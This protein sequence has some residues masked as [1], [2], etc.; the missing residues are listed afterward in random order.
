MMCRINCQVFRCVVVVVGAF[1]LRAG[2]CSLNNRR[3]GTG[4]LVGRYQ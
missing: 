2:R 3:D 1:V 4:I